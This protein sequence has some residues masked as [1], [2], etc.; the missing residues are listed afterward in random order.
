MTGCEGTG[1]ECSGDEQCAPGYCTAQRCCTTPPEPPPATG[2]TA[3]YQCGSGNCCKNGRCSSECGGGGSQCNADYIVNCAG[4]KT[5]QVVNT[6]CVR[7]RGACKESDGRTVKVGTAQSLGGCCEEWDPD[8]DGNL[9]CRSQNV[10]TYTCCPTGTEADCRPEGTNYERINDCRQPTR[11]TNVGD[12]YISHRGAPETVANRC[13]KACN[14]CGQ[15]NEVQFWKYDVITTCRSNRIVCDCVPVC[16]ATA[17]TNLSV[18]Q[19]ASAT[20]ANVSWSVGSGGVSQRL[21]VDQ[22]ASEVDAGCPTANA[23]EVKATL[24]SSTTSYPVTGLLPSTTYYFRVET[25]KNSSCHPGVRRSYTTPAVTLSGRVYLDANNNCSTATPWNLGG[26]T[27]SVRGTLYSGSVGG[28]SHR[29]TSSFPQ[30]KPTDFGIKPT[31]FRVK[32]TNF[33]VKPTNFGV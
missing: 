4:T 20:S 18:V 24:S 5:Q 11:C 10:Y 23:C 8:N 3:D 12:T 15:D 26:L 28:T 14:N 7:I 16:T 6:K 32:P 17:P 19:G 27:V 25:Y 31:N 33:Q 29:L 13:Y 1:N 21:Y 22:S 30:V 9:D 2:C